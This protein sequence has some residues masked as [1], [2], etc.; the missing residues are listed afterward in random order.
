MN[1]EEFVS[2]VELDARKRWPELGPSLVEDTT[3]NGF[4][5]HLVALDVTGELETLSGPELLLAYLCMGGDPRAIQ[6]FEREYIARVPEKLRRDNSP[7][8]VGEIVQRTRERLLVAHAETGKIRVG[9]YS[10]RGS[11]LGWVQVAAVRLSLNF[12][13]DQ[14]SSRYVNVEDFDFLGATDDPALQLIKR[15]HQA[16]FKLVF[17]E[18]LAAL[19][20]EDRDFLRLHI[21]DRLTLAE[22]GAIEGR[23]KSTLSRRFAA[24]RETLFAD[25]R[26]RLEAK[27]QLTRSEFDSLMNVIQSQ[28]DVSL[29][30]LL[31]SDD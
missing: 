6:V 21:V 22:I 9:E 17:A 15:R 12:R 28:L 30:R 14:K 20:E 27:L 25:T 8:I 23:D 29:E 16:D 18:A 4:A 26:R 11:L 5:A 24:I 19:P 2:Q 31:G 1:L 7:S 13:R 10:G 3:M